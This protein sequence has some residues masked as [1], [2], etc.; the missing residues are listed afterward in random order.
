MNIART[1]VAIPVVVH[2]LK[3]GRWGVSPRREMVQVSVG[4]SRDL[5]EKDVTI[6]L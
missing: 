5:R 4:S 3:M 2:I 1:R 6:N